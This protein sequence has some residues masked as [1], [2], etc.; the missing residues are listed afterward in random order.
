LRV[1][2]HWRSQHYLFLWRSAM[3]K[4]LMAAAVGAALA[5]PIAAQASADHDKLLIA[6]AGGG[7]PNQPGSYPPGAIPPGAPSS[8]ATAA[9]RDTGAAAHTNPT[10]VPNATGA[11][12]RDRFDE[13]DRNHDGYIS[14]DEAKNA[15]ELD[16]RFSELDRNNDDKLSRDE[17]NALHRGASGATGTGKRG[18]AA[19]SRAPESGGAGNSK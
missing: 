1:L 10:D 11:S 18:G 15:S 7:G 12:A 13:L 17:Y 19:G 2:R 6:Q 4:T 5:A 14:R 9:D 3:I 16:T 8:A